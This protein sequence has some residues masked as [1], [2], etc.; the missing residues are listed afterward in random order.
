MPDLRIVPNGEGPAAPAKP[1]AVAIYGF[2]DHKNQGPLG[3]PGWENWGLNELYRYMPLDKFSR[4]FELHPRSDFEKPKEQGGDPEHI[5]TLKTFPIPVYMTAHHDDIPPSVPLP[6]AFI[7][8]GIGDRYVTSTPAWMLALAIAEGFKTIG[9]FGIDMAQDCVAPDTP[10]LTADLRWVR[11]G[12]LRRGDRVMAYDE[13]PGIG[14]GAMAELLA[15]R[16]D[17]GGTATGAVVRPTARQWRVAIVEQC[18]RLLKPCYRIS[19]ADGT[20]IVSSDKHRWLT[21]SEH[22]HKWRATEELVTPAHRAGRPTKLVRVL[23]TWTDERSYERGYLAAAFDGEGCL[24]QTPHDHC[25]GHVL[26]LAFAQKENAMAEEVRACLRALNFRWSE[27]AGTAGVK[28]FHVLGGRAETMRFLGTV[29]P[30]RLLSKFAPERLGSMQRIAE[31]AV[32]ATEFLGEQEVVGLKT[33]EGTFIADGFASHNSEYNEQRPC[34]EY[35]VGLARGR[36]I[37]VII[38]KTSD[39]CKA[40]AQ[41]GFESE[42]SELMLKMKERTAWLDRERI[43]QERKL[44]ELEADY[45]NKSG[46][47]T[48]QYQDFKATFIGNLAQIKGAMDD[49]SYWSR[50]WGVRAATAP[51]AEAPATPDRRGMRSGITVTPDEAR[52]AFAGTQGGDGGQPSAPAPAGREIVLPVGRQAVLEA[53]KPPEAT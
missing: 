9:L 21:R 1:T 36:G 53:M 46:T 11:A 45:A 2:T 24:G 4:W 38:P 40:V 41:Y 29:R 26:N 16:E 18:E 17:G 42:G 47:L 5:T 15:A 13:E 43:N 37:K 52:A 31:I 8:A 49:I 44:A 12:D 30:K 7:E 19:L 28:S 48:R 20:T 50:S 10:V 51:T 35:L 22:T 14:T 39:I 23:P 33:S 32:T 3:V 25:R 34:V 27:G 6:R